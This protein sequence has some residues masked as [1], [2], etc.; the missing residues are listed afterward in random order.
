MKPKPKS[1]FTIAISRGPYEGVNF[2]LYTVP[3][4]RRAAEIVVND[5][6]CRASGHRWCNSRLMLAVAAYES[7]L[8]KQYKIPTTD[9]QADEF[10]KWA[11]WP[12]A[13]Q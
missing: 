5:W 6:L 1:H 12:G 4:W 7:T 13:G 8:G 11:N 3:W 10:T 9:T 2:V